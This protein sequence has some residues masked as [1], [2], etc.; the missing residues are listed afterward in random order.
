MTSTF[1]RLPWG[2]GVLAALAAVVTIVF[3][4]AAPTAA[5]PTQPEE[6]PATANS[7]ATASATAS[8]AAT[9]AS[10]SSSATTYNADPYNAPVGDH[11]AGLTVDTRFPD[12][13]G[14][15]LIPYIVKPLNWIDTPKGGG[16]SKV[17]FDTAVGAF[18]LNNSLPNPPLWG[19]RPAA[20][21]RK[22]TN[23]GS[24]TRLVELAHNPR[25]TDP[26]AFDQAIATVM[27]NGFFYNKAGLYQYLG[28]QAGFP[29]PDS[30]KTLAT[31][32]FYQATQQAIW[33]YTDSK[34]IEAAVGQRWRDPFYA[35]IG[36]PDLVTKGVE[37]PALAT[38]PADKVLAGYVS[39]WS[40][41]QNLVTFTFEDPVPPTPTE[42]TTESTT[43]TT[44]ESTTETSTDTTPE[45][46]TETST[47]TTPESSTETTTESTTAT[48]EPFEPVK[49]TE[50]TSSTP[51]SEPSEPTQST[52][53]THSTTTPATSEPSEPAESTTPATST[54]TTTTSSRPSTTTPTTTSSTESSTTTP[55]PPTE[56]EEPFLPDL[57]IDPDTPTF[58]YIPVIPD[59]PDEPPSAVL[60]PPRPSEYNDAEEAPHAVLASPREQSEQLANT[61]ASVLGVLAA[62]GA[63]V[64][65]GMLMILVARKREA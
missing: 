41:F 33:Y 29:N 1:R 30:P 48:T 37:V 64:A 9:G 35:L 45:S 36:R 52:E 5:E 58:P 7:S 57:P 51:S 32:D 50:T 46:T 3:A 10:E 60:A 14:N 25:I 2:L 59:V 27:Y 16:A 11:L 20:E 54:T 12:Q 49:Q 63:L 21:Y 17:D 55:V 62:A 8:T 26:D 65:G 53:T 15:T 38:P 19:V 24:G 39:P 44:T 61:G 13:F 42:T 47:E 6:A 31:G 43:E 34:S 18:C 22:T 40:D 56:P 23:N 28:G 4:L